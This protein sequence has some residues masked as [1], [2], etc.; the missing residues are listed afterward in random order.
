MLDKEQLAEEFES[1][2][3]EYG[4]WQNFKG[5]IEEKGYRVADFGMEDEQ[6]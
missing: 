3:N 6:K 4:Q 5:W 2:L 1:F